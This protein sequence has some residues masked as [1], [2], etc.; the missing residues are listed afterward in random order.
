MVS[1]SDKC[2]RALVTLIRTLAS[3]YEC[4]MKVSRDSSDADLRKAYRTVSKKAHPDHGGNVEDQKR[5][6]GAYKEWCDAAS[7]KADK[8]PPSKQGGAEGGGVVVVLPTAEKD[9]SFWF[10]SQAVLLTFQGFPGN[11]AASLA[12]W[13]RFLTFVQSSLRTW[14][15]TRWTATLETNADG[16]HHAH[17]M[18]QFTSQ[19]NRNVQNFC[20]EG[21]RPNAQQ[22]TNT[23]TNRV[24]PKQLWPGGLDLWVYSVRPLAYDR[25]PG[26][27]RVKRAASKH[28]T[29]VS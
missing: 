3:L 6:N 4:T 24:R 23:T 26:Q 25:R 2:K 10:R 22:Q 17:L 7:S 9:K 28:D 5:L 29:N 21:L 16:K 1:A 8:K 12:V 13:A 19:Q 20:F 11:L 18:L 15:V 14:A 27:R